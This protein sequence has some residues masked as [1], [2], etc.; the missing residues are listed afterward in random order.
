MAVGFLGRG[1]RAWEP[2]LA[3]DHCLVAFVRPST[4]SRLRLT[5]SF[6]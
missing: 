2:H 3:A 4:P 1:G 5:P 6:H